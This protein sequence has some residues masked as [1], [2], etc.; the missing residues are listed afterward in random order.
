MI[1]WL[2]NDLAPS[3]LT[4]AALMLLIWK[5]AKPHLEKYVRNLVKDHA[6]H[7]ERHDDEIEDLNAKKEKDYARMGVLE[8]QQKAILKSQL[9]M[10]LHMRDNNHTGEM[11]KMI[12]ELQATVID[13]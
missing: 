1:D 10:L 12:R 13:S 8:T 11:D 5:I 4:V 6:M 2:V 3:A 9:V 7:L